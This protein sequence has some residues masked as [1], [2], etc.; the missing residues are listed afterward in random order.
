GHAGANLPATLAAV[1]SILRQAAQRQP[2]LT[3]RRVCFFSDLQQTT[4]GEANSAD[5][6]ARL[7]RLAGLTALE[8]IDLGEPGTANLAVAGVELA[9][10]LV[11][12]GSS[13][14]IQAEIQ[15]FARE[16]RPRTPVEI[17]VDG[18]RIADERIDVPAGGRAAVTAMH[19][20][21]TP[22]DHIVEVRL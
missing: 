11:A 17:L 21:D 1:E 19:R 2:R 8:L 12:A 14:Q 4:W 3:E 7:G 6:R 20:F 18:Q 5:V 13:V 9:Q 16:A 10:P 15:S 22:G